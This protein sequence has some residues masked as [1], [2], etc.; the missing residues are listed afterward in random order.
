MRKDK[1]VND[2]L[3]VSRNPWQG[4]LE[5]MAEERRL[6]EADPEQGGE[7]SHFVNN[8]VKAVDTSDSPNSAEYTGKVKRQGDRT[9]HDLKS[10]WKDSVGTFD[11]KQSEGVYVDVPEE[12]RMMKRWFQ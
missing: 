2:D 11:E 8:L 1:S 9:V 3:T 12:K 5:R 7:I 6:R 10:W 4:N